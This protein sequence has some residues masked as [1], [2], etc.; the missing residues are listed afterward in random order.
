M[1][2]KITDR[3]S[4]HDKFPDRKHKTL[5]SNRVKLRQLKTGTG[6]DGIAKLVAQ[7][8]FLLIVGQLEQIEA[9]WRRGQPANRVFAP[10][11]QK[12]ANYTAQCVTL[13]LSKCLFDGGNAPKKHLILGPDRQPLRHIES[14]TEAPNWQNRAAAVSSNWWQTWTKRAIWNLYPRRIR[15]FW[16]LQK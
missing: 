4:E 13:V 9:G 16:N 11:G 7:R 5:E 2:Q 12:S 10:N 14:K 6:P 1:F 3:S 15:N 8:R